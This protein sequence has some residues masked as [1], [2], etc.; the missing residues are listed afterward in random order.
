MKKK[1]IDQQHLGE[2]KKAN[3]LS[4]ESNKEQ[5]EWNRIARRDRFVAFLSLLAAASSAFSAYYSLQTAKDANLIAKKA[6]YFTQETL[7]ME[8]RKDMGEKIA[9]IEERQ[10]KFKV[11]STEILSGN[12]ND[13]R[14]K[15]ATEHLDK[16]GKMYCSGYIWGRHFIYFEDLLKSI[17][18]N[19]K[20]AE[21]YNWN[22]TTT[23]FSRICSDFY[24]D[25]EDVL[26]K[27]DTDKTTCFK[28]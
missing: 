13:I 10:N 27:T 12:I 24:D 18:K 4:A 17:C 20:I 5:S 28:R 1:S 14:E 6:N 8:Q 3:Q 26:F 25:P 16:L 11:L 19:K 9:K 2:K 21:I 23:D 22:S 15:Q 7:D